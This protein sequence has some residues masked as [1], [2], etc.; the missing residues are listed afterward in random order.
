MLEQLLKDITEAAL[1]G[2]EL[3][4]KRRKT[5]SLSAIHAKKGNPADLVTDADREVEELVKNLLQQKYPGSAFFGEE[6]GK[7]T[8][9]GSRLRFIVDPI[10]GTTSFVHDMPYYCTSIGAEVEGELVAGA[11]FSAG[12]GELFTAFTGG[13]AH[14]NGKPIAVSQCTE[15]RHALFATGFG[16]ARAGL[17]TDNFEILPELARKSQGFRCCGAAALDICH[18]AS[19]VFDG[20]WEILLQPYDIAAGAVILRE[21]GGV[22]TDFA[23]GKE[24]PRRGTVGANPAMHKLLA[25]YL[26]QYLPKLNF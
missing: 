24:F 26:A 16:C 15:I 20:V 19:G 7:S 3:A 25:S 4:A 9:D 14:L 5:L 8:G 11:V 21:A 1:Q 22:M 13:G 17:T 10:D 23:G 2:G 6:T 12:L 18:T